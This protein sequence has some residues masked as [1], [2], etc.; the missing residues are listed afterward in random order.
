MTYDHFLGRNPYSSKRPKRQR[1]AFPLPFLSFAPGRV[2]LALVER[3][4][5]N[6]TARTMDFSTPRL[7]DCAHTRRA[8]LLCSFM[9]QH[10][11]EGGRGVLDI[12][13]S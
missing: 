5:M 13:G 7:W 2:L 9:Y 1:C 3:I 11:V 8:R 4:G 12:G 6:K 10:I